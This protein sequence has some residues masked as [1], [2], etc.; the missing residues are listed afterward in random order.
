MAV[1]IVSQ[2]VQPVLARKRQLWEIQSTSYSALDRYRVEIVF[3]QPD[4][5]PDIVLTQT[6]NADGKTFFELS[7]VLDSLLAHGLPAEGVPAISNDAESYTMLN[8]IMREKWFDE[9]EQQSDSPFS[10]ACLKA[11][12]G[13]NLQQ[14]DFNSYFADKFLCF[15]SNGMKVTKNSQQY[16]SFL[17][18]ANSSVTAQLSVTGSYDDGTTFS[19]NLTEFDFVAGSPLKIIPCSYVDLALAT[20][21]E[22]ADKNIDSFSPVI[23]VDGTT[24]Q[25]VHFNLS[26]KKIR[27]SFLFANSAGGWSV[28]HCFGNF[29][30]ESS[31][32]YENAEINV[33]VGNLPNAS[34]FQTF[35]SI[36][37]L[38]FKTSTGYL[39][40]I[41][42]LHAREFLKSRFR[43]EI[44]KNAA[45]EISFTPIILK[46]AAYKTD[47]SEP[48]LLAVQFSY[49]F[50]FS[51][52]LY[53]F[54]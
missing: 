35:E 41:E 51:N 36:E 21:A 24:T 29:E 3:E 34:Q 32:T 10:F 5:L 6:P 37:Q 27:K 39:S 31:F 30:E 49:D 13:H 22:V 11:G 14:F 18:L 2:P 25:N 54:L 23:S 17:W 43:Y 44:R 38:S 26:S 12:L 19:Y 52:K 48:G 9:G 16:L 1:S 45:G 4:L 42:M 53:D 8:A 15:T 28:L 40:S 7:Q 46:K 47:S 50:A 20:N 33:P